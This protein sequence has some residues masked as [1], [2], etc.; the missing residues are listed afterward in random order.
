M[1][2]AR[3]QV[4]PEDVREV[5]VEQDHVGP[6]LLRGGDAAVA[7]RC[8]ADDFELGRVVEQHP[9]QHAE[10]RIVVD[11]QEPLHQSI[12]NRLQAI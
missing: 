8:L 6:E 3:D 10:T 1:R 9:G 2:Q 12:V 11:Y 7:V 5:D 4:E